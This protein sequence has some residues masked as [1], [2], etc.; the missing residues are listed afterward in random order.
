MNGTAEQ[1]FSPDELP[2]VCRG[3]LAD[4]ARLQLAYA[5]FPQPGIPEVIYLADRKRLEP[6]PLL[7]CRLLDG[8]REM[9]SLAAITPLLGW[10]EREIQ[11]LCGIRFTGHPEPVP[12][13]L[14]EGAQPELPPLDPR[15]RPENR[16][17]Y[18]PAPWHLPPVE[19]DDV[20]QL[21]FGPV[22]ADVLESAQIVFY[23]VGEGILHCH[24]R[25]FFKHRGI[26]K[27]F[28]GLSPLM[29]VVL[30]ER[31]SGVDSFAHALAFCQAIES[32]CSGKVPE[33]ALYLRVILAELERLYNHLHYLGHLCHTTTLKVGEAQG[34]LFE[35]QCKQI[36]GVFTGSRFLRGLLMPGG[37]RR[38]L[39]LSGLAEELRRLEPQIVDYMAE[40]EATNSHLD[41]LLTTGPLPR[42]VA[43]DQGAS[44]PIKRASGI[45][46]D[47]RWSHPY[48][49]YGAF[50][51]DVPV[52]TEG[53]AHARSQIRME[54]IR[55]S[56]KLIYSALERMPSGK[57]SADMRPEPGAEGLGWCEST[58]GSIYH[59][60]HLDAAGRLA[61]VKVK[62]PSFSNWR[63]FPFTVHDSNMMDYAINEASFGLTMAGCDR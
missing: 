57:V 25:L 2:E 21:P 35:E 40:L 51:V 54:E 18:S 23:Y 24:P 59:C 38:D 6:F 17:A 10:Y 32:T 1:R 39:D 43:F 28:E 58:R 61:R 52:R 44:G 11:D 22:R 8:R 60:V 16:M 27:Q 50:D 13:V 45:Q 62:S 42:Q 14:H 41:R 47:L 5:W 12:L 29:G 36:N 56:L 37:L 48:A 63:V 20:Q 26:E 19:G 9:P 33:R 3:L 55:A 30:A 46:R 7:R 15:Y 4:G 34:K 31:I 49:A 53:D